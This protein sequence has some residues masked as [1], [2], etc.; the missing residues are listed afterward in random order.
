MTTTLECPHCGGVAVEST[1]SPDDNLFAEGD[2]AKVGCVT[3]GFPGQVLLESV[4][5]K[6]PNGEEEEVNVAYWSPSE[7]PETKCRERG[8]GECSSSKKTTTRRRG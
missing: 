3:C 1:A 5:A 7:E 6:M 8:C 2:G 4:W